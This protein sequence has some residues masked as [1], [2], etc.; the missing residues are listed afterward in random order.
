M[1]SSDFVY[2]T[3]ESLIA[4]SQYCLRPKNL[5]EIKSQ[6][7]NWSDFL[8]KEIGG[9]INMVEFYSNSGKFSSDFK[10]Y[11]NNIE[12]E[13]EG[14]DSSLTSKLKITVLKRD[15]YYD[16]AIKTKTTFSPPFLGQKERWDSYLSYFQDQVSFAIKPIKYNNCNAFDIYDID[17]EG[18][19]PETKN[20]SVDY[21][22]S[23]SW[24][25]KGGFKASASTKKSADAGID[26]SVGHSVSKSSKNS[27][28]DFEVNKRTS[29]S[30]KE[31]TWSLLMK[32]CYNG[33]EGVKYD[34]NSATNLLINGAM[35]KWL[36][37]VPDMAKSD[38]N[39]SFLAAFR[40]KKTLNGDEKLYF[41]ITLNQHIKHQEIIGRHGLKSAR[42]GGSLAYIPGTVTLEAILEIDLKSK[43]SSIVN[44]KIEY[45]SLHDVVNKK[46]EQLI[47]LE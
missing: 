16:I 11:A 18:T 4:S 2:L 42:I 36:H 1:N 28:H 45:W 5:S 19:A 21:A 3:D 17:P 15:D 40:A 43:K 47:H 9:I 10:D 23:R 32:N 14:N 7:L 22:T 30:D 27:S 26:F 25:V 20:N 24:N 33:N 29:N 12:W 35:T 46:V 37:D 8:P 38:M 6:E 44:H 34:I 41:K 13:K 31:I 39:P